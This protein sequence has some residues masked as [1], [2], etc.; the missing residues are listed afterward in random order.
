MTS[1]HN[2]WLESGRQNEGR[3]QFRVSLNLVKTHRV[4]NV[5][6]RVSN[7]GES[8]FAFLRTLYFWKTY[9]GKE[10][11]VG[12]FPTRAVTHFS[13]FLQRFRD[14]N[15]CTFLFAN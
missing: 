12:Q 10:V 6:V 15:L 2:R 8:A 4:K 14:L 11:I 13:R 3:G 5:E 7:S 9:F 1:S